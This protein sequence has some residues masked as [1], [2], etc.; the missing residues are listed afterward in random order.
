M[1]EQIIRFITF[2]IVGVV[3]SVIDIL[4]YKILIDRL[5]QYPRV[6]TRLTT[7]TPLV[8]TQYTL[9]HSISFL[10]TTIFVSY[11]LNRFVTY[12]DVSGGDI[13]QPIKF[14]LVSIFTWLVTTS[15][16]N[17]LTSSQ[18]VIKIVNTVG[19]VESAR[20]RKSSLIIHHW[21]L[22]AKI[23]LIGV[24]MISNF[25]GYSLIFGTLK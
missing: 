25:V 19:Y 18:E 13:W 4:I 6:V 7:L 8:K 14:F 1:L 21:P 16:L 5:S 2:G 23:L 17:W 20:S 12:R 10:I 3:N 24:S 22:I 15:V 9:S 11:P